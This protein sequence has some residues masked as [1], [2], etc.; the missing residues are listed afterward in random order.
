MVVNCYINMLAI[1]IKFSYSIWYGHAFRKDKHNR[2][3]R[4][5]YFG[6][7]PPRK[8]CRPKK[9]WVKAAV[10][11]YKGSVKSVFHKLFEANAPLETRIFD[12]ARLFYIYS[13]SYK[14]KY[15]QLIIIRI[16][17]N[18]KL[19]IFNSILPA[20]WFCCNMSHDYW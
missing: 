2:L 5:L 13:I 19:H 20:F 10:V 9:T 6:A 4:I 3:R 16:T 15:C 14:T 1:E 8:L 12:I 17:N 11:E 7:K 18:A